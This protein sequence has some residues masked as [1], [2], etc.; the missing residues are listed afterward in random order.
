MR[1]STLLICSAGGIFSG[2]T[3]PMTSRTQLLI[4]LLWQRNQP[5]GRISAYP[6]VRSGSSTHACCSDK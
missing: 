6:A 2:M 1:F 3:P 5:G 4:A